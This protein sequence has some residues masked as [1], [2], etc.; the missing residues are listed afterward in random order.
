MSTTCRIELSGEE[1]NRLKIA[2]PYFGA[3]N[4]FYNGPNPPQVESLGVTVK[5]PFK[6]S[7]DTIRDIALACI[8]PMG[9][10]FLQTLD[11]YKVIQVLD[12]F[13]ADD[14][15]RKLFFSALREWPRITNV[16]QYI[17]AVYR[18]LG[19]HPWTSDSLNVLKN[20][21]G[22]KLTIDQLG[23]LDYTTFQAQVRDA[24]RGYEYYAK[25]K[26][27]SCSFCNKIVIY[28][29]KHGKLIYRKTFQLTNCCGTM[30]HS[31][32]RCPKCYT[33]C[34]TLLC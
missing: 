15:Y 21:T 23:E 33:S 10:L 34:E 5:V 22:V 16:C 31:D 8:H 32:Q 19:D 29:T 6:L 11:K 27:F 7:K 26:A 24:I 1:Y 9:H 13:A 28:H 25:V 30:I 4:H 20:V 2:C 12:Y 3:W 17:R 18:V 14:M